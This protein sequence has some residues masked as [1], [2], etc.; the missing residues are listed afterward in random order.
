MG[1]CAGCPPG[2]R[3]L[4]SEKVGVCRTCIGIAL[5]GTLLGWAAALLLAWSH[6]PR[7]LSGLA[8]LVAAQFTLVLLVH[9]VA[10]AARALAGRRRSAVG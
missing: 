8:V 7:A 9:V 2:F 3:G 10:F 6:A 5:A 4:M 1:V